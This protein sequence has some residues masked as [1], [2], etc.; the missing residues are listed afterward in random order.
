M[1][2]K[3]QQTENCEKLF[4]I[5]YETRLL[6]ELVD[7]VIEYDIDNSLNYDIID[8]FASSKA[9]KMNLNCRF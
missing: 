6:D 5:N 3:F 1:C 9:R 2:K 4:K 8:D 7:C